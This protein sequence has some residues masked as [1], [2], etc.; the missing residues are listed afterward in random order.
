MASHPALR[1]LRVDLLYL[2]TTYAA[3]K[4]VHPP[5]VC[6]GAPTLTPTLTPTPMLTLTRT[7]SELRVVSYDPDITRGEAYS[8]GYS[9]H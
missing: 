5:Q 2:D 9:N 7:S 4:H 1:R 8:I 6:M 3:P